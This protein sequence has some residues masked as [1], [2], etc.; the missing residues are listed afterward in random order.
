[1]AKK[2]ISQLERLLREFGVGEIELAKG[3]FINENEGYRT[4]AKVLVQLAEAKKM[5]K[6]EKCYRDNKMI[7]TPYGIESLIASGAKIIQLN[8]QDDGGIYVHETIYEGYN[9]IAVSEKPFIFCIE[10]HLR[11]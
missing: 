5:G 8:Q 11:W 7:V 3:I 6:R 4:R 1:M 9:F 10:G 2:K